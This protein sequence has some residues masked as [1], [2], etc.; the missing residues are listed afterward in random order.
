MDEFQLRRRFEKQRIG[1]IEIFIC[2]DS[3]LVQPMIR[4]FNAIF[5]PEKNLVHSYNVL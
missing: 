2:G 3:L 1:V 5:Q 4:E